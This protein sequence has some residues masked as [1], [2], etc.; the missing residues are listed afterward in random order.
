MN[1]VDRESRP[2]RTATV[3]TTLAVALALICA[4]NSSRWI[5]ATFPG[6]FVMSNR[7]I[8]SVTLPDWPSARLDVFQHQVLSVNGVPIFRQRR[9]CDRVKGSGRNGFRVQTLQGRCGQ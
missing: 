4:L 6:F 8:A 2:R 1:S 3:L 5:G 9:L 7:V